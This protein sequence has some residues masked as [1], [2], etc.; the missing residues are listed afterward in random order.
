MCTTSSKTKL[1]LPEVKLGLLPGW[2]GTQ[3]LP[4]L[5]GL[6]EALPLILTGKELRAD[7]AKKLGLVDVTCDRP[8]LES[9]AVRCA[10]ELAA[11]TLKGKG[12][13]GK[14]KSWMRWA[15]EDFAP[16]RNY[17]FKKAAEGV[18]KQAGS[19]DKMPAPYAIMPTLG[20]CSA[21]L[22]MPL[23]IVTPCSGISLAFTATSHF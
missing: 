1:G 7:K 18:A 23:P 8:S 17:V 15:T 3:N 6:A 21:M 14:K 9:L 16:G 12:A 2:G 11:G 19:I 22:Y 5:V 20:Y 10:K 4:R 13:P